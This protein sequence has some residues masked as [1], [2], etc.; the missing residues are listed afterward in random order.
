M[1][2]KSQQNLKTGENG[3]ILMQIHHPQLLSLFDSPTNTHHKHTFF[4]HSHRQQP[5]LHLLSPIPARL[6]QAILMELR[7]RLVPSLAALR[8]LRTMHQRRQNRLVLPVILPRAPNRRDAST[9]VCALHQREDHIVHHR[10]VVVVNPQIAA[11]AH[12]FSQHNLPNH[13]IGSQ[14]S[15]RFPVKPLLQTVSRIRR[16]QPEQMHAIHFVFEIRG[17]QIAS[18]RPRNDSFRLHQHVKIRNHFPRITAAHLSIQQIVPRRK[19]R[20]IELAIVQ[21]RW[22]M[23][24]V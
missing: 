8:N 15:L 20:K 4:H 13:L 11:C 16:V 18:I 23:M 24:G 14:K 3:T 1:I 21:Q 10:L 5:L 22:R 17:H 7:V 9:R 12:P 2:L 19:M 6:R